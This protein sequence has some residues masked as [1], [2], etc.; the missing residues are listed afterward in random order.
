[1][2]SFRDSEKREWLVRLDAPTI[3][4]VR[5]QCE[6]DLAAV[7]GRPYEKMRDDPILLV[8]VLY[9]ICREQIK[10]AGLT[11]IDFGRSLVGDAIDGATE[12]MG[13]A[14]ADF[15]P[16][17]RREVLRAMVAKAEQIQA[18]ASRQAVER[19]GDPKLTAELEQAM[20]ERLT[21]EMEKALTRLRSATNSPASSESTP[22]DWRCGSW[23]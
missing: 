12:A 8:D 16:R 7:D 3:I 20:E 10:Q 23:T 4:E 2:A 1:M 18:T 15:S 22:A 9:V 11:D 14:I 17:H 21:Q 19:L 6:I 13:D 5:Q